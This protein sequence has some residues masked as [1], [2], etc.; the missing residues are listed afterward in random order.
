MGKFAYFTF[1]SSS[2]CLTSTSST[3]LPRLDT[4]LLSQV[5][6]L[7]RGKASSPTPVYPTGQFFGLL[8]VASGKRREGIFP[9]P[10]PWF[11]RQEG[12]KSDLP[13]SHTSGGLSM[14]LPTGPALLCYSGSWTVLACTVADEG[15]GQLSCSH[16]LGDS[17]RT[18]HRHQG[19][20]GEHLITP[21]LPYGR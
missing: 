18:H 3:V 7:V 19:P 9:S 6:H 2:F 16:D 5:L 21:M 20:F 4:V 8:Q 11:G 10:M 1:L 17:S 12:T 15:H 13:F 14:P